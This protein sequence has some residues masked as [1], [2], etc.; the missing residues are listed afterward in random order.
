MNQ[1]DIT[2][3]RLPKLVNEITLR[4]ALQREGSALLEGKTF[5]HGYE[6]IGF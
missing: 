4:Y 5:R 6:A 3:L 2:R 1:D